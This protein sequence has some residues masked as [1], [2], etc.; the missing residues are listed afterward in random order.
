MLLP[1]LCLK[2]PLFFVSLSLSDTAR[3][4]FLCS[5]EE[6]LAMAGASGK[7]PGAG[8]CFCLGWDFTAS[9]TVLEHDIKVGAAELS[10]DFRLPVAG[11]ET[12]SGKELLA[13]F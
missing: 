5:T 7:H 1:L 6:I 9:W 3:G 2:H 12:C 13:E 4:I 11:T 8:C 10:C